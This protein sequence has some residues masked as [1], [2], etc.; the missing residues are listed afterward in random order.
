MVTLGLLSVLAPAVFAQDKPDLVFA[1]DNLWPTLDPVIGISTTGA[2]V[3]G[4]IF[5]TLVKR[6]YSEDPDGNT[7]V[8][9]L[10]TSWERTSDTVWTLRIREG[11]KFHNGEDMTAEDVAFSLSAER[12]W[13]PNP[14]A[15]R[16]A[17][18]ARGLVRVEATGLYT[19]EL[20][21]EFPDPTFI[22]RLTTVIGYVLP[23]DYYEEVGTEAFGLA[24]IGTG[25]YKLEHFDSST[26]AR[27]VANE[28]YW[29]GEVPFSKITWQIVPEYSTRFA[30]LVSGEY[31]IIVN[32]PV[33]QIPVVESTPGVDL[34]ISQVG[35]YPMFIFNT[36][37]SP[38]T[39]NNPLQDTN[40]RKAMVSAINID[41][42]TEALW[43][44]LTYTP[45]PFNFP[46]YGAY[47]DPNRRPKYPYNPEAAAKFLK[48][49]NYD[50]Q[51]LRWHIVRGFF[52]NY[53]TA[54]E[55]M[56]EEW[57]ALG[58]NVQIHVVDNFA[59]AYK[60]PFHLL[61]MSMSSEFTG[62]PYRPLWLDWG[63]G[64]NRVV[65]SHKSW[66]PTEAFIEAG[67]RFERAQTF[68]ERN[69][70]YLDML[71]E[72]EEVTPAFYLWRNIATYALSE[73]IDW[74]PGNTQAAVFTADYVSVTK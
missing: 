73:D 52:E 69:A 6:N 24:P 67:E 46:E 10:A 16:G 60:P 20:E 55:F 64:S 40:L 43:A 42:I 59:L 56:V 33:D 18:F 22:N 29:G 54:A 49:S 70:A 51:V 28:E 27:A 3:Y 4:N 30:G 45:S 44:G 2:R 11:V 68:E 58:I 14:I 1:V 57:R 36:L 34:L 13:G 5:D 62:D 48:A 37:D 23:K 39:P 31:D 65:A 38:E 25:P 50:G 8:P 17:S 7:I 41:S 32:V 35:N 12:L 21:T 61:N 71:E 9:G 53:E 47:Y 63:P 66:I 72:W 74:N 26:I 19:V 15:P